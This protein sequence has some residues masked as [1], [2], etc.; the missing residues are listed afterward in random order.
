VG[1][2]QRHI[3]PLL[4]GRI[5]KVVACARCHDVPPDVLSPGHLDTSAP[6]DVDVVLGAYEAATQSCVVDC[7]FDRD[8]GP[9]WT[10]DSGAARACGACHDFPPVLTRIGTR[11]PTTP[12]DQAVCLQCHAFSPATHVDGEVT[13]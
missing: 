5:G 11:H 12:P 2:H 10:D 7:H 3:D 13:F 8:P 6:A 4:P 1:A 9:V